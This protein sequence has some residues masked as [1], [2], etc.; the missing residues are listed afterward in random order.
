VLASLMAARAFGSD[1]P[2]FWTAGL[3]MG[4]AAGV[5]LVGNPRLHRLA[6]RI[7]RAARQK[8]EHSRVRAS[9]E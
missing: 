9:G 8:E 3:L 6:D 7:E 1:S 4:L 2:W 5:A